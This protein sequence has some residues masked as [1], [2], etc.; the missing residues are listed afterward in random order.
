MPPRH[1]QADERERGVLTVSGEHAV[2][3]SSGD[4]EQHVRGVSDEFGRGAWE[5]PVFL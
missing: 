1:V 4:L 2:D 5:H 3:R